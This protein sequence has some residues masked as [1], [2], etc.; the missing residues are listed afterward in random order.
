[1]GETQENWVTPQNGLNLQL[2]YHRQLKTKE[3][4]EGVR[5][6]QWWEV[7]RK[8]SGNKSKIVMHI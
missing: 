2:I 7:Y 4:D 5:E 8:S 6:S 3:D 1:M